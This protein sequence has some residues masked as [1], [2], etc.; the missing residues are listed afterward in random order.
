MSLSLMNM[1]SLSSSVH[2]ALIACL[3][4]SPLSVQPLQSRSFLSY[5]SY[6]TTAA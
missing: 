6:A 4:T 5:V 3:Y 2:I 1:L